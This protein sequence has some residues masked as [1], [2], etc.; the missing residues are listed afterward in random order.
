[1]TMTTAP[2]TPQ[3]GKP[4][5]GLRFTVAIALQFLASQFSDFVQNENAQ[6]RERPGHYIVAGS[7]VGAIGVSQIAFKPGANVCTG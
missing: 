2:V 5:I 7:G 1:M 4:A 6:E 3:A